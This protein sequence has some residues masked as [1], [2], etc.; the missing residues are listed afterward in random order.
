ML[1][2]Y[3]KDYNSRP[4][5]RE[6]KGLSSCYYLET[7]LLNILQYT[8]KSS[9]SIFTSRACDSAFISGQRHNI[10]LCCDSLF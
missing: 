7:A 3:L 1:Q 10:N 5:L 2:P 8:V 9:D 4:P 6:K